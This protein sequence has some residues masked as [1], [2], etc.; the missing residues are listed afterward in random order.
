MR[1]PHGTNNASLVYDIVSVDE[2]TLVLHAQGDN[3][4]TLQ[5]GCSSRSPTRI[6]DDTGDAEDG[7]GYL[8]PIR[9]GMTLVWSD[10][11]DGT[12]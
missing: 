5:P 3:G 1:V 6:A 8:L 9:T 4:I 10:E 7:E 12:V 11:F 2:S